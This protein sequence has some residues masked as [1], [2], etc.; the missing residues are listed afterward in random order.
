MEVRVTVIVELHRDHD[1]VEAAD[2]RHEG[3]G[4]ERVGRHRRC[5]SL[6]LD[7][8]RALFSAMRQLPFGSPTRITTPQRRPYS[9]RACPTPV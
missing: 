3:D 5:A 1:P 9:E 2:G 7:N 6:V 4:G 8:E